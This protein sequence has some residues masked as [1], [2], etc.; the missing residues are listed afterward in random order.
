MTDVSRLIRRAA[1]IEILR[2]ALFLVYYLLLIALGAAILCGTVIAVRFL[3]VDVLPRVR[4]IRAA[5]ALVIAAAGFG[6]L[7][8]MF[9]FYLV[10]PIFS[11]TRDRDPRRLEVR[12]SDCPA[13]FALIDALA[14]RTGCRRPKRVFLSFDVNACVFYD[15][16]FWSIFLPVRK[17][18]EVGIGLLDGTSEAEL[19]GVLA[20]EFGHF[21][22]RSMKVGSGAAV[23]CTVLRNLILV[24]DRWD[25]LL[26]RWCESDV[27]VVWNLF[28]VATR[29]LTNGVRSLTVGMFS[30][31]QKGYLTLS[32]FM[33]FGADDAA[34][35][36]VSSATFASAL[37]KVRV[38]AEADAI[39]WN[40]LLDA[41]FSDG[42]IPADPIAA[43][44]SVPSLLGR[45]DLPTLSFDQPLPL[46]PRT[47]TVPSRLRVDDPWASH[48]PLEDRLANI[49]GN[50]STAPI[51]PIASPDRPAAALVPE[52]LVR[53]V[54]ER[55]ITLATPQHGSDAPP[56][57]SVGLSE[58]KAWVRDWLDKGAMLPEA[59]E[60]FLQRDLEPFDL[61][62]TRAANPAPPCPLS[63][64]NAAILEACRTAESDLET[65]EAVASGE[66]G[67]KEIAVDGVVFRR[68]R[69]PVA[70]FRVRAEALVAKAVAIQRTLYAWLR[71]TLDEN[72]GAALDAEY[73]AL[74]SVTQVLSKALPP[75]LVSRD[76]LFGE[77]SRRD[78]FPQEIFGE[79]CREMGSLEKNLREAI[80]A[81]DRESFLAGVTPEFAALAED[82]FAW[83]DEGL[84]ALA[85]ATQIDVE[86]VNR[87]FGVLDTFATLVFNRRGLA[88]TAIA[89]ACEQAKG[90]LV[91]GTC[92]K[93]YCPASVVQLNCTNPKEEA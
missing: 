4:Y 79:V 53:S 23:T 15:T 41:L 90:R 56:L 1:A 39:Y 59:L 6:A 83:A 27:H 40:P 84:H 72:A 32:R 88:R 42:R 11:F 29:F 60:P 21:G 81:I 69:L 26:D 64:E 58:F 25:R 87:T 2:I 75:L 38:L 36:I 31:V 44:R 66:N 14:V 28:G 91:S 62:A 92:G 13:L 9:G 34:C 76:W 3:M 12:R 48:P 45:K 37:C 8:L 51:A 47:R 18:L 43:R 46:P 33:E 10:K 63:E 35:A 65:I 85:S 24:D 68:K 16:S 73:T 74:F 80:L 78:V 20:H 77:L 70:D 86:A 61:A 17:N 22:Q 5:I 82:V 93:A 50:A 30:F 71:A 52:T 57:R 19:A 89:R 54:A 55:A 7:A 67:A 49:R